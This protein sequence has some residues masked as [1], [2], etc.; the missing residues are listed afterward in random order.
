MI[1]QKN[2]ILAEKIL[3]IGLGIT[4][5]WFGLSQLISPQNWVGFLPEWA[6]TQSFITT[7]T[8]VYF[9]GIFE[10]LTALML[11]TNQYSKTVAFLLALHMLIIIYHLGYND[12]A[13]RDFGLFVGFVALLHL[14][15]N[16]SILNRNKRK[17]KNK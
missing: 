9:N 10:T 1:I 17:E 8:L 2:Y 4:I 12:L 3:R 5:L 7:I 11:V 13:V 16:V 14:C 15:D 6:F